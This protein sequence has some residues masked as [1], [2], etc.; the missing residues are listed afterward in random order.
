GGVCL[1]APAAVRGGPRGGGGVAGGVRGGPA[2]WVLP[3]HG[4]PGSVAGVSGFRAG[5]AAGVRDPDRRLRPGADAGLGGRRAPRPARRGAVPH[6]GGDVR[7]DGP[8]R[9][10]RIGAG[11]VLPAWPGPAPPCPPDRRPGPW[12]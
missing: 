2:F 8:F 6:F 5:P 11:A 3:V 1:S 4:G 7:D 10:A 9:G 12:P